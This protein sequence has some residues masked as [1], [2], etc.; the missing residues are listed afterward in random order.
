MS[1]TRLCALLQWIWKGKSNRV[2]EGGLREEAVPF[3]IEFVGL[4]GVGKTTLASD[5]VQ[6]LE[7]RGVS[8]RQRG[9]GRFGACAAARFCALHP[10]RLI[11]FLRLPL[12][13]VYGAEGPLCYRMR[14]ARLVAGG[15]LRICAAKGGQM[16]LVLDEGPITWVAA[17]RWKS[18]HAYGAATRAAVA[19]YERVGGGTV[20]H[21]T[22]DDVRRR[23]RVAERR[24][25]KIVESP[26]LAAVRCDAIRSLQTYGAMRLLA[27][28]GWRTAVIDTSHTT[29]ASILA[30]RNERRSRDLSAALGGLTVGSSH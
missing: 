6:S 9:D 4:P 23:K 26:I 15:V 24:G 29:T 10:T 14:R 5:F 1:E 19:L 25:A 22:C 30:A 7:D 27:R 12:R 13:V 17:T 28:K 2:V 3:V 21:V 11:A 20:V 18:G 16:N 8:V